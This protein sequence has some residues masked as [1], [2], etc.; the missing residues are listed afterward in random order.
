MRTQSG[1]CISLLSRQPTPPRSPG[2]ASDMGTD[3]IG[4]V[5]HED[6]F[7]Q[8][9]YSQVQTTTT[10]VDLKVLELERDLASRVAEIQSLEVRLSQMQANVEEAQQALLDRD[11]RLSSLSASF[12]KLQHNASQRALVLEQ[13]ITEL[14]E[15]ESLK[16]GSEPS[17]LAGL[18]EVI[19]ERNASIETLTR[20][21]AKH[22]GELELLRKM[23]NAAEAEK[24]AMASRF[25]ELEIQNKKIRSEVEAQQGTTEADLRTQRSVNAQL[26]A[27]M[28]TLLSTISSLDKEV[29]SL[30]EAKDAVDVTLVSDR[31]QQVL[32]SNKV[33]EIE[34]SNQSLLAQLTVVTDD[35]SELQEALRISENK[36]AT[37]SSKILTLGDTIAQGEAKINDLSHSL[38][39]AG[40]D[41]AT[42]RQQVAINES[43][44]STLQSNLATSKKNADEI[45]AK[46]ATIVEERAGLLRELE[47]GHMTISVS[48]SLVNELKEH[49]AMAED[50]LVKADSTAA[51]LQA[52][53]NMI[54]KELDAQQEVNR[55]LADD[56]RKNEAQLAQLVKDLLAANSATEKYRADAAKGDVTAQELRSHLAKKENELK[57]TQDSLVSAQAMRVLEGKKTTDEISH[58]E[59]RIL[60]VR[61]ESDALNLQLSTA[62]SEKAELHNQLKEQSLEL[63]E[64]RV[65]LSTVS[66]RATGLEADLT[67]V[68]GRM[69]EAEE[70][71]LDLRASKA[72]DEATIENL[73]GL[74]STHFEKQTETLAVLNSQV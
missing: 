61:A 70:E 54:T 30:Q 2:A 18:E 3:N 51:E 21:Q 41:A 44:V 19:T 49:L 13:E 73:K 71:V 35:R 9:L 40:R 59:S 66:Q 42:L 12:S 60:S 37:F 26:R 72:A 7:M 48:A 1:S 46:L 34:A 22:L 57:V 6:H 50:K 10:A 68:T 32:V 31:A 16:V 8:D 11:Q 5:M 24:A 28:E 4:F 65:Q 53:W 45:A 27:K 43:A 63:G 29:K 33:Q 56:T 20:D 74:F 15:L 36:V 64:Y 39:T 38:V 25:A 52:K 47:K 17:C 62:I 69:Q 23:L 58:L 67:N 14:R 55:K